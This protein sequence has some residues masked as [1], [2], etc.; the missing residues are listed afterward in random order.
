VW[1]HI[2]TSREE[3]EVAYYRAFLAKKNHAFSLIGSN[4][5]HDVATKNQLQNQYV[6][7]AVGAAHGSK[8]D[9]LT[10]F[11]DYVMTTRI[12]LRLAEEI[13]ACYRNSKTT[14]ELRAALQ[15]IG[16]EKKKVKLI[17]ERDRA[18]AKKLRKKLSK[19]FF[20]PQALIKEFGL[21]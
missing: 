9:Y 6:Q 3:S 18:K 8:T 17:I 15:K 20:V 21:Y 13:D 5:S 12:S 1:I 2:G 14:A 16:I 7:W 4:S 19:E 11:G 10:I